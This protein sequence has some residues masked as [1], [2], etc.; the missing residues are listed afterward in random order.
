[1]D[2]ND[3]QL[4]CS[5]KCQTRPWLYRTRRCCL[6]T[7]VAKELQMNVYRMCRYGLTK[8]SSKMV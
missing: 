4:Q 5:G 3:D 7:A 1:M 8:T 6:A 2:Q